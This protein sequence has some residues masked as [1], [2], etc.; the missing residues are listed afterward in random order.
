[1][2]AHDGVFLLDRA[3]E[4]L[5]KVFPQCGGLFATATH[6]VVTV[7][8]EGESV[9]TPEIHKAAAGGAELAWTNVSP[10]PSLVQA[11]L[12]SIPAGLGKTCADITSL[13]ANGD[14]MLALVNVSDAPVNVHG[15]GQPFSGYGLL[16]TDNGGA[17]W[18]PLSLDIPEGLVVT[19]V[20]W[21][22]E[23]EVKRLQRRLGLDLPLVEMFSNDP[24]LADL[25]SWDPTEIA[26]A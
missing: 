16:T 25:A 14:R 7:V 4:R 2:C 20:L 19:L 17:S 1:M 21:N 22:E 5:D 11:I 13:V 10:A 15:F 23:L 8:F 24:R 18:N 3:S 12:D 6:I 9:P 26:N